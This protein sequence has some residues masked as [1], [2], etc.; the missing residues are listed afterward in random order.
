MGSSGNMAELVGGLEPLEWPEVAVAGRAWGK[1][2]SKHKLVRSCTQ[3]SW[4]GYGNVRS[5]ND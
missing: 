4:W 3:M 2:G 5:S 1:K